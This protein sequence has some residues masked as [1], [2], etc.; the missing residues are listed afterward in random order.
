MR[1]FNSK[2]IRILLGCILAI[3]II[4]VCIVYKY[5]RQITD[6]KTLGEK[7][8]FNN[9]Y[10]NNDHQYKSPNEEINAELIRENGK[11]FDSV[12][13][14]GKN[15]AHELIPLEDIFYTAIENINW[16]DNTRFAICGHVNPSLDVYILIDVNKKQIS[17]KYYGIGFCLE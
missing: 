3:S 4:S 15:N 7:S 16:V 5:T 9:N 6:R 14:T 2:N 11:S 13:I 17:G 12:L 1:L 8:D 10:T